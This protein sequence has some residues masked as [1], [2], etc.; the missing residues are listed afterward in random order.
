MSLW[1]SLCIQEVSCRLTDLMFNARYFIDIHAER[2]VVDL[3][4]KR[5]H[6]ATPGCHVIEPDSEFRVCRELET[7]NLT[8][9][10][11]STSG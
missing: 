1:Q 5:Q 6:F 7:I 3:V 8:P 11:P 9:S 10:P 4:H 2:S